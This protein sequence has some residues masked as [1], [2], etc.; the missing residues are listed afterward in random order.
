[1]SLVADQL[2]ESELSQFLSEPSLAVDI[3]PTADLQVPCGH[4]PGKPN[5]ANCRRVF[6]VPGGLDLAVP[7]AVADGGA[8]ASAQA[9]VARDQQGVVL[10]FVE[11]PGVGQS[12]PYD[13]GSQCA[14]YGF[15]FAAFQLCMWNAEAHV[16]QVVIVECPLN[17]SS[18]LSCLDDTD[19]QRNPGWT[20]QL[21]NSFRRATVAYATT[22]GTILSYEYTS[23]AAPAPISA[24]EIREGFQ[25]IFPVFPNM[26]SL[27][28]LV[29]D[30]TSSTL[31]PLY[32][33]PTIIWSNLNGVT[34]L[35]A[36][37]P[38]LV[39][40]AQDTLQCLLAMML[41]FSQPTIFARQ[42][43]AN[44]SLGPELQAFLD[45]L[46]P[47]DTEVRETRMQWQPVVDRPRL[48]VYASLC[49][50][51]LVAC[52]GGLVLS[53]FGLGI[54][55]TTAFPS[56]DERVR[57]RIPGVDEGESQTAD[58][59]RVITLAERLRVHIV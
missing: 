39:S 42:L 27:T 49:A 45:G 12:W 22:N 56:W 32:A 46:P 34:T 26:T 43:S 3:T 28:S 57:C 1:V 24:D 30:P 11:G 7:Q 14:V 17:V 9:F 47:A 58:T 5:V 33:M 13:I 51:A 2:L 59:G 35:S 54:P 38:A 44:H 15:Q 29:T 50:A 16:I 21:T 36:S 48:I 23:A 37:N 8:N 6:F 55:K 53:T 52:V 18:S 20:T 41:Y 4:V 31:F 40:R 25:V 10:D 19:W